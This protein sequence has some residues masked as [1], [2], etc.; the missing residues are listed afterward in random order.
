MA[1]NTILDEFEDAGLGDVRL[2]QRLLQVAARVAAKPDAPFPKAFPTEA[3]LEGFYRFL[4]N[5]RVTLDSVIE[6]HVQATVDRLADFEEAVAIHDT[7]EMRFKGDRKGLGRLQQSGKGFMAHLSMVAAPTGS[8]PLGAVALHAWTRT[9]ESATSKRKKGKLKYK[10]ARALTTEQRRWRQQVDEVEKRIAGATSL[11]HVM[12][13]EADDYSLMSALVEDS[14][15]FVVRLGYD[16]VLDVKESKSA[17]HR[18]TRDFLATGVTVCTRKV[19]LSR[20]TR[21]VG[22]GKRVRAK[23]RSERKA[24]LAIT[25]K[26]VVFRRPHSQSLELPKRLAVNVVAVREIDG[27]KDAEPVE[28]LLITGEPIDTEEQI[29]RVVDYYR[30]RWLIE[31]FFKVL[32][33]GCAYEKRLLESLDTLLVALGIFLPIAWSLLR[34]R[35]IARET[36]S[37]PADCVVTPTQLEVLRMAPQCRL[38]RR[39]TAHDVM[40]AIAKL[41]GHLRSN[42]D[43]GWIVLARGY[44]ELLVLTAGYALARRNYG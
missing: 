5:D 21:Q 3:E 28:W 40:L 4:G 33:T 37:V 44:Q 13:S 24:T 43:P 25:A 32:K 42:G 19:Q 20:R 22:G 16:R 15:R 35:S 23:E 9:E 11:I 36:P 2:D 7:S 12:D 14:R 10:E 6:P 34:L 39:P 8:N 30:C 38:P 1:V 29:L 27:P 17:P 18:K 26:P 41:G 31:E